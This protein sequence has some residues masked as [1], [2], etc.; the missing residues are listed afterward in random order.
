MSRPHEHDGSSVPSNQSGKAMLLVA[1]ALLLAG[2]GV[3]A[4]RQM[5]PPA[6]PGATKP[7]VVV[8]PGIVQIE[9]FVI[10]LADPAGDRYFR[11]N[12]QLVL[13]Q[14]AIAERASGQFAQVKIRDKVFSILS[15]KLARHMATVEG[16]ESLRGELGKATEALFA[17][18]PLYD[19]AI[20]PAPAKVIDV[21]FTEF[22]VQ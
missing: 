11:L 10:N 5:N 15:K 16:K 12:L 6:E 7:V 3:V 19:A 8:N 18:A 21:L 2:G 14:K 4:Y 9:P 20:D 17:E 13:D 22:L 1:G